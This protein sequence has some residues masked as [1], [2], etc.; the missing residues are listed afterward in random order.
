MWP[1]V[2]NSPWP[3]GVPFPEGAVI[4][5]LVYNPAETALVREARRAGLPAANGLGM[6]VEQAA[7]A[8]ELWTGRP[9]SRPAMRASVADF[10][11]ENSSVAASEQG[12]R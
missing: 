4:Y 8:F 12:E 10:L 1:D 3:V 5:D 9:A 2:E 11:T 6:L 7:L